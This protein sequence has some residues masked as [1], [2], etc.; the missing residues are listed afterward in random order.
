VTITWKQMRVGE[1]PLLLARAADVHPPLPAVLWF[2][3]FGVEKETHRK[4]LEQLARAGFL[5][6]GVDAA[7]H[8]ERRL[9]D[10][11]ARQAAPRE[12]ALRTMIELAWATAQEVPAIIRA[13]AAEGVADVERVAVAGVSMGGYVV[14]RAAVVEPALCAAV[15]V[16]GSPAWP[17]G[18][19]PHRHLD[20]LARTALLSVTAARDQNVPPDAARELHHRLAAEHPQS[21]QRYVEIEGAEHLMNGE[22]WDL[23]M[24][25]TIR[26]LAR[27][28]R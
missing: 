27:H 2:H 8:G 3:G 25:E 10:L 1:V 4:E 21:R 9:P 19:S 22:Q 16:L 13:L 23:A 6:V 15:S 7:G 24:D 26:W 12:Q 18:D 17:H 28:T 20:A 5:A 11:D 14:Y